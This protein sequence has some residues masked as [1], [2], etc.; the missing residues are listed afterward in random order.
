MSQTK[1]VDEQ[2]HHLEGV[3][4]DGTVKRAWMIEA[5]QCTVTGS[6]ARWLHITHSSIVKTLTTPRWIH[7]I[8]IIIVIVLHAT[9]PRRASDT[10]Q[11]STDNTQ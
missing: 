1:S 7:I 5:S 11:F 8:I 10:A 4:L 2:R 6:L 9:L 3:R